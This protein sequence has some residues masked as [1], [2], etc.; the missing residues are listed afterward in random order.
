MMSIITKF[1][2]LFGVVLYD[3]LYSH[4]QHTQHGFISGRSTASI[5]VCITQYIG[6]NMDQTGQVDVISAD[7]SKAF[8]RLI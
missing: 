6:D 3:I 4:V 8:D 7:F 5:L 2:K 1:V